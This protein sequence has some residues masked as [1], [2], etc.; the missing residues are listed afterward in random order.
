[1][2]ELSF[3]ETQEINGGLLPAIAGFVA[4][5]VLPMIINDH[6]KE[7]NQWGQDISQGYW[8]N[9]YPYDPNSNACYG[10]GG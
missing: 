4:V 3:S 9:N 7:Y 8:D 5:F 6:R 10:P 1:M 2:K